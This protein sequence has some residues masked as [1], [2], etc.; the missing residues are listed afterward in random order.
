MTSDPKF[1]KFKCRQVRVL[2][3]QYAIKLTFLAGIRDLKTIRPDATLQELGLDSITTLEIEEH[4]KK[5]S[6]VCFMPKEIQGLT[7]SD[8]SKM[9]PKRLE[10][11]VEEQ[12]S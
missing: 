7:Y 11:K 9:T 1:Y 2:K 12:L 10:T 6:D 4:L 3:D 5:E 8:L